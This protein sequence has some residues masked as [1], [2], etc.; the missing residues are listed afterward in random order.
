MI[1]RH[2]GAP[3]SLELADLGAAPP[4][5]AFNDTQDAVE[6]H[7]PLRVLV[8]EECWLAQTDLDK[9]TLDYDELFTK[10]YPYFSSTS[11][12]WVKHAEE[13]VN[14]MTK[15]LRLGQESLTVEIGSND[16]YLL[17]FVKTPC[18]GVEPTETSEMAIAK[19]IPTYINFFSNNFAYEMVGRRG[20]ADWIVCN[21]VLA[22]VPD[23]NDFVRGIK[24]L[25]KP[26]G[27]A[28]FEFPWLLNLVEKNQ[29]DTLYHEHYSYLSMISIVRILSAANLQIC[30]VEQ[31]PTH[32]GSIRLCVKH[33]NG[34]QTGWTGYSK[35]INMELD[36]GMHTADFYSGFQERINK[37]KNDLNAFLIQAKRE[38]KT[39]AGF[40]AA[41]KGNTM[42]NYCGVRPDL[43]P[44]VVDDTPYKQGKYMPGSRI[45]VVAEFQDHPDY[46]L[47]LPWNFK[48]EIMEKL[49][50]MREWGCKFVT[51]IPELEVV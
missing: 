10:K 51:A 36:A 29:W 43:L 16:G 11:A 3:L 8:C 13:L 23:I 25:L 2:C 27:V 15:Q 38:G 6:T 46:V 47:I 41:A 22:H 5:N 50:Y 48:S 18:Y 35:A 20:K 7:Y 33:Y 14:M 12:S 44:Y 30:S 39:V 34:L 49:A 42:L 45:P 1:C 32:G 19:G 26:A 17:Q 28:T 9:F 37:S 4:S 21:N 31:M 40:G 24:T